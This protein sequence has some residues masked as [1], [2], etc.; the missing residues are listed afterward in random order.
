MPTTTINAD[1]IT[2]PVTFSFR[3]KLDINDAQTGEDAANDVALEI[4]INL[5]PNRNIIPANVIPRIPDAANKARFPLLRFTFLTHGRDIRMMIADIGAHPERY[6]YSEHENM[7][8][9]GVRFL[10]AWTN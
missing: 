1:M 7:T 8:R 4:P 6:T 9:E 3:K 2:L 10:N 5:I